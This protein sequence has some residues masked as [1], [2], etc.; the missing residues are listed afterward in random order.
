MAR[1]N[2]CMS[3]TADTALIL[4]SGTCT[5]VHLAR[6]GCHEGAFLSLRCFLYSFFFFVF[7]VVLFFFFFCVPFFFFFA[8][9][10][11]FLFVLFFF[12]FFSFFFALLLLLST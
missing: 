4:V 8:P 6:V 11:F 9:F 5:L 10:F 1:A 3:G 7:F 12:N 2:P